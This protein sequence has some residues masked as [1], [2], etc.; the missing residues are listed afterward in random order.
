M[1]PIS[2][3]FCNRGASPSIAKNRPSARPTP[4]FVKPRESGG[5][6]RGLFSISPLTWGPLREPVLTRQRRDLRDPS[7]GD[8]P[9][10][11]PESFLGQNETN[12]CGNR[13]AAPPAPTAREPAQPRVDL[14]V[15]ELGP[16]DGS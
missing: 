3:R 4:G 6:G 15:G 9:G 13:R 5:S 16:R 10:P 7:R 12:H 1:K 8:R 11:F 2:P 14:T